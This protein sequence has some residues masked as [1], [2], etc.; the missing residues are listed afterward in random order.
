M[1]NG[2]ESATLLSQLQKMEAHTDADEQIAI[3]AARCTR[4]A[5]AE[6]V[7]DAGAFVG[8]LEAQAQEALTECGI[9]MEVGTLQKLIAVGISKDAGAM[10]H[11]EEERDRPSTEDWPNPPKPLNLFQTPK[12]P[13]FPLDALPKL[14][15]EFA[16]VIGGARGIAPGAVAAATLAVDSAVLPREWKITESIAQSRYTQVNF[17]LAILA[18]PSVGKTAALE[19]V[20]EPLKAID[21]ERHA[22]YKKREAAAAQT[23]GKK[24]VPA[25]KV[26]RPHFFVI[27]GATEE[28]LGGA[29][30]S[31]R[32]VLLAPGELSGYLTSLDAY[33]GKGVRSGRAFALSYY[34]GESLR[35]ARAD[36]DIDRS[37][38]GVAGSI[39]STIQTTLLHTLKGEL[40]DDGLIQRFL[41]VYAESDERVEVDVRM[42]MTAY[43]ER[44]KYFEG[45][46]RTGRRFTLSP[47]ARNIFRIARDDIERHA[48][49]LD[50]YAYP[51]GEASKKLV[52]TLLQIALLI[53]LHEKY[54][55]ELDKDLGTLLSERPV[56]VKDEHEVVGPD[57]M[58]RAVRLVEYFRQSAFSFYA[59]VALASGQPHIATAKWLASLPPK[60]RN[61]VRPVDVKES[62]KATEG[63]NEFE[64]ERYVFSTLRAAGWLEREPDAPRGAATHLIN[65]RIYRLFTE[66]GL[67]ERERRIQVHAMLR[68]MGQQP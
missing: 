43:A 36:T 5:G 50:A 40:T 33:K 1:I 19:P 23:P 51:A 2:H 54:Q 21:A 4:E 49:A 61:R 13:E 56:V 10:K 6:E 48:V 16:E 39:V 14:T 42:A 20:L 60:K 25:K 58:Q 8:D 18:Q 37:N 34:D 27:S 41:F 26:H 52:K 68:K 12:T 32:A 62:V 55:E 29:L 35:I 53:H 45:A 11:R 24:G 57:A 17:F 9:A 46:T 3:W 38:P 63:F 65:P 66:L 44:L 22:D 15:Q 67:A 31:G 7:L 59:S 30:Q 64:M 28:G 47:E